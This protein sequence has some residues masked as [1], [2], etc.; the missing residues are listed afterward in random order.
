MEREGKIKCIWCSH[1]KSNIFQQLFQF[2]IFEITHM[3]KA[4]SSNMT[5]KILI[6]ILE[7]NGPLLIIFTTIAQHLPIKLWV[8]HVMFIKSRSSGTQRFTYLTLILLLFR[9]AHFALM[10]LHLCRN[11]ASI[12]QMQLVC[13]RRRK[14]FWGINSKCFSV[15]MLWSCRFRY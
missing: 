6:K 15:L 13:V 7:L 3:I 14:Q 2:S 5:R 12:Y 11:Y 9:F 1:S 4:P 8:F 10:F